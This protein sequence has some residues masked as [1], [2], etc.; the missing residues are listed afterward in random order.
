M[1]YG[2]IFIKNAENFFEGR[3]NAIHEEKFIF[4]VRNDKYTPDLSATDGPISQFTGCAL[5]LG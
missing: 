3:K 4:L 2:V 1:R 5:S